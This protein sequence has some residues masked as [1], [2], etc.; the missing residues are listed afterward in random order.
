MYDPPSPQSSSKNQH[1][2]LI[3]GT[4]GFSDE[5]L[6]R[7]GIRG[8]FDTCIEVPYLTSVNELML[9][10]RGGD[11]KEQMSTISS[12]TSQQLQELERKLKGIR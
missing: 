12:F 5:V 9:V 11:E 4:T 2:L 1:K 10:L 3:I 6:E 7:T 8:A